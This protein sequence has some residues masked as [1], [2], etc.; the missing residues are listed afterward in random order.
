MAHKCLDDRMILQ[1]QKAL[2]DIFLLFVGRGGAPNSARAANK[3]TIQEFKGSKISF[4]NDS[5]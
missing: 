3:G 5:D 4:D 1:N 2:S